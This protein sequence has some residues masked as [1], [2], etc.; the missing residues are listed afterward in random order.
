MLVRI[1]GEEK[2]E[3]W[4][5]CTTAFIADPNGTLQKGVYGH[6]GCVVMSRG[7]RESSL[8][9]AL[10][11]VVRS[12]STKSVLWQL[13]VYFDSG[14]EFKCFRSLHAETLA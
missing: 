8:L 6:V 11:S 3:I 13:S 5:T 10:S 2:G 1:P 12:G 7:R 9:I 4:T 14:G